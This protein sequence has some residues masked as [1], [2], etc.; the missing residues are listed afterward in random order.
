MDTWHNCSNKQGGWKYSTT[1]NT[2]RKAD[3]VGQ[4]V[5]TDQ[6]HAES[7]KQQRSWWSGGGAQAGDK[8]GA[9]GSLWEA[10]MTQK[11]LGGHEGL[12]H[13]KADEGRQNGMAEWDAGELRGRSENMWWGHGELRKKREL[14]SLFAFGW[15]E[16]N[17]QIF[18]KRLHCQCWCSCL[19]A[20]AS[21]IRQVEVGSLVMNPEGKTDR[22]TAFLSALG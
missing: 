22:T 15:C 21:S 18:V 4:A 10:S 7:Q 12:H 2:T 3:G 1:G 13:A 19:L 8:G 14:E 16:S 17:S 5:R 11:E 9:E 6:G 20:P